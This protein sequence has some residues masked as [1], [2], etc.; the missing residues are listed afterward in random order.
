MAWWDTWLICEL[1]LTLN[2]VTYIQVWC[3]KYFALLVCIDL[4]L[5][6][7]YLLKACGWYYILYCMFGKFVWFLFTWEFIFFKMWV[8][9]NVCFFSKQKYSSFRPS[10]ILNI[11]LFFWRVRAFNEGRNQSLTM[12]TIILFIQ[13]NNAYW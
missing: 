11:E 13:G 6:V 12:N 1:Y 5:F 10:L 7:F 2:P 8:C 9:F 3:V 4:T